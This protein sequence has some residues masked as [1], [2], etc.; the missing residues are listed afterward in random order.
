MVLVDLVLNLQNESSIETG[1]VFTKK[2][3]KESFCCAHNESSKFGCQ[4]WCLHDLCWVF[5]PN[6]ILHIVQKF[7]SVF[8]VAHSSSLH[9]SNILRVCGGSRYRVLGTNETITFWRILIYSPKNR[10]NFSFMLPN[11]GKLKFICTTNSSQVW[12]NSR[13]F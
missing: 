6:H 12:I 3:A 1:L 5:W 2:N 11:K 13:P 4:N 10:I 8:N 9:S 7:Q